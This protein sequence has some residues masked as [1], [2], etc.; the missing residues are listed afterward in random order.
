MTRGRPAPALVVQ[1]YTEDKR[2]AE[3]GCPVVREVVLG[4]LWQLRPDLKTNHVECKPV[5]TS[6]ER[7][8]SGSYWKVTPRAADPGAQARRITL[9]QDIVTALRRG[10]VVVFHVD[11][12]DRW[13]KDGQHASVW[14]HLE[15]LQ[16]DLERSV[17]EP[18]L[19]RSPLSRDVEL[20]QVFIPAVPFYSMESWAYANVKLLREQ[21]L[22][23][24]RE[25]AQGF[26][27]DRAGPRR[28][29]GEAV[30]RS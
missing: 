2:D 5:H 15:R 29:G 19:G 8:V 10:H 26:S 30:L 20:R 25:A 17:F 7:R 13:L 9:I 11:G 6:P 24:Y 1:L 21:V 3:R 14:R 16:R 18:R 27:G 12:D 28:G 4:M 22:H 23:S